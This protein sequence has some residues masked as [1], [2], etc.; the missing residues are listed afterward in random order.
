M[1]SQLE[2]EDPVEVDSLVN[3]LKMAFS[4][5]NWTKVLSLSKN[6]HILASQI[7]NE[8]IQHELF[9]TPIS[10]KK[11]N[12]SIVFYFGY[13]YLMK[14]VAH[15]KLKQYPEAMKCVN[16]Y[17]DLSWINDSSEIGLKTVNDFKLYAKANSLTLELLNGNIDFLAEYIHLLKTNQ[18][19]TLPGL[20]T[21]LE[22][23][24]NNNFNIDNELNLFLDHIKVDGLYE[25]RISSIYYIH[26]IQMLAIYEFKND[27]YIEAIDYALQLLT[28]S[29]HVGDDSTFKKSIALFE[30]FRPYA[31]RAQ[32]DGYMTILANIFKLTNE[33][34]ESI[35]LTLK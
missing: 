29:D 27:R 15:Q 2:I 25:D 31:S 28:Y 23:A 14:G 19:E 17:S 26:L 13:S 11:M 18:Q 33:Y 10:K 1:W 22:S 24:L 30:S 4:F 9:G 12:R 5:D 34:E 32:L 35:H 8:H 21:L 3:M 6:L 7:H 16:Y 20:L